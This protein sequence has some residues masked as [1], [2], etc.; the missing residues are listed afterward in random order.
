MLLA[1]NFYR[2]V[3]QQSPSGYLRLIQRATLSC[4]TGPM[5]GRPEQAACVHAGE[6][7][8]MDI[9][10]G[11]DVL[12]LFVLVAVLRL[13]RRGHAAPNFELAWAEYAKTAGMQHADIYGRPAAERAFQRLLDAGLLAPADARCAAAAPP[14]RACA[15]PCV[16]WISS[17]LNLPVACRQPATHS[18]KE[19]LHACMAG[20]C[21]LQCARRGPG[22]R[23]YTFMP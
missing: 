11:L 7:L 12:Q 3:L 23:A 16:W 6:S 2:I 20:S 13:H 17:L 4:R 9:V 19:T 15:R 10:A 14:C 21:C 22:V 5:P 8:Q 1:G 18:R